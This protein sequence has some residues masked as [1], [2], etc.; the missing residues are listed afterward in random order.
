MSIN[1]GDCIRTFWWD[2]FISD[3]YIY[4]LSCSVFTVD[5]LL[6]SL[7]DPRVKF[8]G[9]LFQFLFLNC[10]I[11]SLDRNIKLMYL[12]ILDRIL[13]ILCMSLKIFSPFLE[14]NMMVRSGFVWRYWQLNYF[15]FHLEFQ[16]TKLLWHKYTV[17]S[18]K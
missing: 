2:F 6:F 7:A 12:L 9:F 17:W 14:H 10:L 3:M 1:S 18:S 4:L 8:I 13:G 11:S 15:V 16:F 5:E